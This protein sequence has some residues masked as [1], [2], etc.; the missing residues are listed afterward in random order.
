MTV[1]NGDSYAAWLLL[2]NESNTGGPGQ[3][4]S[5]VQVHV[6]NVIIVES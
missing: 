2:W 4:N 6:P 5:D 1:Q 3:T